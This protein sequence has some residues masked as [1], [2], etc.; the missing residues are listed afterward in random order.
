MP[1]GLTCNWGGQDFAYRA[2]GDGRATFL[3]DFDMALDSV[4]DFSE[5]YTAEGLVYLSY[6]TMLSGEN[7]SLKRPGIPWVRKSYLSVID[8]EDPYTQPSRSG[9]LRSA[10]GLSSR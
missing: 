10:Q 5:A 6:Q 7:V 8:Y 3:S 4:W 2:P 1:F 9:Q